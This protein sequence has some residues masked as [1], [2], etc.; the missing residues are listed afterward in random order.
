MVGGTHGSLTYKDVCTI[1]ISVRLITLSNLKTG[2]Q[3]NS[4]DL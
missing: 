3:V 4:S 1:L 2:S